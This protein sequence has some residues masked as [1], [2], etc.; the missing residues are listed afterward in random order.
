MAKRQPSVK[1]IIKRYLKA[2]E[3]DNIHVNQ[4]ILFGSRARKEGDQWS[5]IDI[6]I[7]SETFEG[8]RFND[9]AR[10]RKTTLSVSSDLSPIPFRPEDF[11]PN[12]PFV[13]EILSTGKR[14]I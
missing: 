11:S 5:D 12:D 6:A 3:E 2:L 8:D 7:V 14:V 1:A 9:R 13:R 10:I 4:A